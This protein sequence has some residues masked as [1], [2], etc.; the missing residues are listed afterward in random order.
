MSRMASIELIAEGQQDAYITGKPNV[1]YFDAIYLRHT[2]FIVETHEIP[3]DTTPRVNENAVSTLPYKGDV[4]TDITLR[5]ILP[6]LYTVP[7]DTYC[8][9]V[10]PTDLPTPIRLYVLVNGALQ[11][12]MQAAATTAYWSTYNVGFW[13]GNFTGS[14]LAV[15]FNKTLDSFVFTSATYSTI[16]FI[17]ETS[18]SFWGFDVRNPDSRAGTAYGYSITGGSRTAQLNV[19]FSGWV[20]GFAPPIDANYYDGVGT[21]LVRSASLLIGGQHVSTITGDSIDLENDVSVPYENQMGLT[22]LVGKNDTNYKIN[23]RYCFTELKFGIDKI[24]ICAL[25]RHDVQVEVEFESQDKLVAALNPGTGIQDARSYEI[26]DLRTVFGT[27]VYSPQR[28]RIYKDII[29]WEE[30][31]PDPSKRVFYDTTKSQSDPTAYRRVTKT[32]ASW[33]TPAGN[34]SYTF[35][36][37]LQYIIRQPISNFFNN[38]DGRQQSTVKYWGNF[39]Y[40]DTWTGPVPNGENGFFIHSIP[41]ADARYLYIRCMVN[42]IQYSG[43]SIVMQSWSTTSLVF[44]F[45]GVT[46]VSSTVY[47]G[48]A[49]FWR[50]RETTISSMTY[51]TQTVVGS[52]TNITYNIVTSSTSDPGKHYS[53]LLMRYDTFGDFNSAASYSFYSDYRSLKNGFLQDQFGITNGI[54][55]ATPY[56]DG[57]YVNTTFESGGERWFIRIDSVNFTSLSGWTFINMNSL[58][59]IPKIAQGDNQ[60]ITDGV[61]TYS[62]YNAYDNPSGSV[63]L[64]FSASSDLSLNSSWQFFDISNLPINTIWQS[65]GFGYQPDLIPFAFDGRYLYWSIGSGITVFGVMYYDTTKPFNSASSWQWISKHKAIT[66]QP[67]MGEALNLTPDAVDSTTFGKLASR[68]A[69]DASG[70][71]YIINRVYSDASVP[72]YNQDGSVYTNLNPVGGGTSQ[73]YLVKYGTDGLVKWILHFSNAANVCKMR[74][75]SGGNMILALGAQRL[76]WIYARS[77]TTYWYPTALSYSQLGSLQGWCIK[78]NTV[79]GTVTWGATVQANYVTAGALFYSGGATGFDVS[80]DSSDNSY[81]C[82]TAGHIYDG[83]TILWGTAGSSVVQKTYVRSSQSGFC[84]F[85]SK[86]NSAGA[87]Q[88]GIVLDSSLKD[89]AVGSGITVT[90]EPAVYVSGSYIGTLRMY[91]STNALFSSLSPVNTRS[92]FV[93]KYTVNGGGTSLTRYPSTNNTLF[94][95]CISSDG[96]GIYISGKEVVG[97]VYQGFLR[98]YSTAMAVQWT[99]IQVSSAPGL[100]VGVMHNRV[101]SDGNIFLM[102]AF[103]SKSITI[104]NASGSIHKVMNNTP[105]SVQLTEYTDSFIIKYNSTGT[106]LWSIRIGGSRDD[107]PGGLALDS[108]NNLFGYI[109]YRSTSLIITN[110]FDTGVDAITTNENVGEVQG[111]SYVLY[112]KMNSNGDLLWRRNMLIS[113]DNR[114]RTSSGN[115]L[116]GLD[117][118]LDTGFQFGLQGTRRYFFVTANWYSAGAGTADAVNILSFDP[119]IQNFTFSASVLVEY[120]YLGDRELEWFQKSR[121]NFLLEQKQVLAT[122]LAPGKT[123]LP[124]QFV[125]PVTD[126]WVTA[127]TAANMNTYTYSNVSSLALT[128]NGSELFNYDSMLF[129]LVEPFEVADSFPT[130]NMYI[131][132][133]SA[134]ANFSRIREKLLTVEI[135]STTGTVNVQV[136]AKTFNVLVVQNGLGGLMFNSYT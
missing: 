72:I 32:S 73:Q 103:T 95:D 53:P 31:N 122:T 58:S 91:N 36:N 118:V 90:S 117:I 135:P 34:Y 87:Y 111:A 60:L 17:D 9:P 43:Y 64:R 25:G 128:L 78:I 124:L 38:I 77:T 27:T 20:P 131:Y 21:R 18:A 121:H 66:V 127:R 19:T 54:Y 134:P 40:G 69:V 6:S 83:N 61:W 4:I 67:E 94:I 68:I 1:T 24:P 13:A 44:K 136:W 74:F 45:Y 105:E 28:A 96:S 50:S 11:L 76:D 120:A 41:C 7:N 80:L 29:F 100:R 65:R 49:T 110:T 56:F 42:Y 55:Q 81:F 108:S 82:G 93:A 114:F 22:A 57:R 129:G 88:W 101:D 8:Y 14:G 125:G 112:F 75:D 123:V 115:D 70:N 89:G 107:F 79:A 119:I 15:S 10:W 109:F 132:H 33:G 92:G 102:G 39:G 63:V 47:N 133:F 86:L 84:V 104:Y 5:S 113:Y 126:L 106:V 26:G 99:A 51:N 16:Y 2:P 116:L 3:F 62:R 48:F 130:R 12:A 97:S 30:G 98:K 37:D 35:S 52:D 85:I 23:P 46:S 59:P 71:Y